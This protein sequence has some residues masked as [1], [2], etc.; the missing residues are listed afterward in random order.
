MSPVLPVPI[1]RRE[2]LHLI[3]TAVTGAGLAGWPAAPPGS[4]SA[5]PDRSESVAEAPSQTASSPGDVTI[6][7][8]PQ[9]VHG[10]RN[11]AK[12]SLTFHGQGPV[13]MADPL[14]RDAERAGHGPPCSPS[15]PGSSNTRRWPTGSCAAV[16]TWPAEERTLGVLR[17]SKTSRQVCGPWRGSPV[18]GVR[19]RWW[20][21]SSPPQPPPAR[22][23][24]GRP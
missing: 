12:V 19:R 9:V 7:L 24:P 6:Q 16:T 4:T 1:E 17:L 5:R 8:G 3:G 11:R 20:V 23:V 2:Y 15:G 10:P 22:A 13:P 14:L 21:P 18:A